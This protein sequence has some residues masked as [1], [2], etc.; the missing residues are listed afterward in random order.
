MTIDPFLSIPHEQMPTAC[1]TVS[2]QGDP[3]VLHL[4]DKRKPFTN[5]S[6]TIYL[7]SENS[8]LWTSRPAVYYGLLGVHYYRFFNCKQF[9]KTFL[10]N[11]CIEK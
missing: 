5:L 8:S 10:I 11:I 1:M 2:K 6:F 3:L 7:D 9:S 4:H